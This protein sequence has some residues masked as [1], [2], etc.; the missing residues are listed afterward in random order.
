MGKK[1]IA[2]IKSTISSHML[3]F[4]KSKL[5][6]SFSILI[7][8]S[9][10]FLLLPL[11][12][13]LLL[14]SEYGVFGVLFSMIALMAYIN[15]LGM[16]NGLMNFYQR[17]DDK[18]ALFST[19][20]WSMAVVSLLFSTAIFLLADD[21]SI[22]LFKSDI[23]GF[24]VRIAS[25]ILLF[26][27]LVR[28]YQFKSIGKQKS[29]LYFSVS[30]VRGIG[31]VLMNLLLLLCLQLG[32][33]GVVLSYLATSI[34]VALLVSPQIFK[35]IKLSFN[36]SLFNEI[37]RFVFPLMWTSIFLLLLNFVDRFLITQILG[38]W[39]A[40]L[41]HAVYRMGMVLNIFILAFYMG[42]VPFSQDWLNKN[43]KDHSV[44]VRLN[45]ILFFISIS[46]ALIFSL[47]I[48]HI[49]QIRVFDIQLVNARYLEALP[50]VPVILLSYVFY[51]LYIGFNL[52]ILHLNKNHMLAIFS[53]I[54]CGINILLNILLIP[55]Y[56]VYGAALATLIAFI[57][58]AISLYFYI[59]REVKS[60]YP[61][62]TYGIW[63]VIT[64]LFIAVFNSHAFI[65][66]LLA[67]FIFECFLFV[68][69]QKRGWFQVSDIRKS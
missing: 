19:I 23:Y 37:L 30:L 48:P 49:V 22:L 63:I 3:Q 38:T 69:Y 18:Q 60:K 50:I 33:K 16:E 59:H 62:T 2:M 58:L 31:V 14:P 66:K 52:P 57:V 45:N 51:G 26:D 65:L 54:A 41:Y 27:T 4:L 10:S 47:I 34:C 42:G 8:R 56:H 68:F 67:I 15:T 44:F 5:I 25:F 29:R 1:T 17:V 24:H 36:H 7:E 40:G 53:G 43:P 61:V 9:V 12:T 35:D 46:M 28:Y 21:V 55:K 20:F 6:Y 11:F 39:E 13:H 64:V 32:L